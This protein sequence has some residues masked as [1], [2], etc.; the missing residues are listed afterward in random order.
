MYPKCIYKDKDFCI[1]ENSKHQW[2]LWDKWTAMGKDV[3]PVDIMV[4]NGDG[5]DGYGKKNYGEEMITT[6]LDAQAYIAARCIAEIK[7]KKYVILEGTPYHT[8]QNINGDAQIALH[9]KTMGKNAVCYTDY[10]VDLNNRKFHY[11]HKVGISKSSW[12][13]R[14]TPVAK[15]LVTALLNVDEV[16]K[17][18]GVFRGHA[19]YYVRVEFGHHFG[20]ILPCWQLRTPFMAREGPLNFIPKHGYVLVEVRKNGQIDY[21]RDIF[22]F[23]TII[24]GV[25][26]YDKE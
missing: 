7:A 10:K 20:T 5:V 4:V 1:P 16:G 8:G 18:D 9:L 3:G 24:K 19:H 23:K 2:M 22:S 21:Q 11:A 26:I 25:S 13:Y 6:D 12:Q 15:E 17:F 14:A